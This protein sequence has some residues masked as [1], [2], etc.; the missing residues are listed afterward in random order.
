MVNLKRPAIRR[1]VQQFDNPT[2]LAF[3]YF[4]GAPVFVDIGATSLA[5]DGTEG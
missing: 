2:D 3:T 1:V 5:G 4:A